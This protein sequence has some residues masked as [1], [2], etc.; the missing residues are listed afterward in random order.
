METGKYF[1]LLE[2]TQLV[3]YGFCHFMTSPLFGFLPCGPKLKEQ[4]V[5]LTYE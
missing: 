5:I 2:Q 3:F 4:E 1:Q